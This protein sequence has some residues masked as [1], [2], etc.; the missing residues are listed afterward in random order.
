MHEFLWAPAAGHGRSAPLDAN[1][2]VPTVAD[3]M[4]AIMDAEEIAQA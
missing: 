3:Q 2:E 4:I 1:L